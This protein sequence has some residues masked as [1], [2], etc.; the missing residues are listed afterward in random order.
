MNREP[1]APKRGAAS[2][3][4]P[5]RPVLFLDQRFDAR[6]L[7]QLRSAVAA[8]VAEFGLSV[9]RACDILIAVHELAS[10]TVRHGAGHGRLRAWTDQRT[11]ICT[12]ADGPAPDDLAPPDDLAAT[13]ADLPW[14]VVS[15]HGLWL[16]S[17]VADRFIVSRERGFIAATVTFSALPVQADQ[18]VRVR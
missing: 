18:Q 3:R 8:H 5:S 9:Q 14:P 11:L 10:N 2:G 6:T 12:I 13:P 15:G 16:V 4:P 1:L 7:Y 17:R